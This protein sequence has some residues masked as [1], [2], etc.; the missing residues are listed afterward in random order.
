VI[1]LVDSHRQERAAP[2]PVLAPAAGGVR[3]GKPAEFAFGRTAAAVEN[4]RRG[5]INEVDTDRRTIVKVWNLSP[6]WRAFDVVEIESS[7]NPDVKIE[8]TVTRQMLVPVGSDTQNYVG[9]GIGYVEDPGDYGSELR[10]I[11][12]FVLLDLPSPVP[13]APV[14]D[15]GEEGEWPD[16]PEEMLPPGKFSPRGPLPGPWTR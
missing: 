2:R 13:D 15:S 11:H 16:Y 10:M 14:V 12:T 5:G 8:A 3:W 9:G 6:V 4:E 7:E 1:V